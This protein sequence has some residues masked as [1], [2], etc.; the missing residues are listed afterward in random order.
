[1]ESQITQLLK[2]P[3]LSKTETPIN[4]IPLNHLFF[5]LTIL[6]ILY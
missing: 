2:H 4:Q 1:M 5:I 6:V 3:L